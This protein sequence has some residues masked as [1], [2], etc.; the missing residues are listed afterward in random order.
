MVGLELMQQLGE[1]VI[2]Q[3]THA[4]QIF[5]SPSSPMRNRDP[6]ALSLL[7][8]SPWE[9]NVR[10]IQDRGTQDR[11]TQDRG[12]QDR[13]TQDRGTQDRSPPKDR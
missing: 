9:Q 2:G 11:G 3:G 12:T 1:G 10:G 7:A 13:G 4:L 8:N 6:F 5:R